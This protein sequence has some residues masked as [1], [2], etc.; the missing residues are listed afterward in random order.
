[1]ALSQV[2]LLKGI[3]AVVFDLVGT[4]VTPE[5][6]VEAVYSAVGKQFG[7]K[8]DATTI[9]VRFRKAFRETE[10]NGLPNV[11]SAVDEGP[12]PSPW[13]TSEQAEYDRWKSI[14]TTS[15]PDV[16]DLDACF[17]ALWIHFGD[18]RHWRSYDDAVLT[19]DRLRQQ[20]MAVALASNFDARAHRVCDGL[21]SIKL[22]TQRFISSEVGFRK[23]A[24]KF[25]DAVLEGLRKNVTDLTAKEVLMVGD[26]R[27][28]DVGGARAAGFRAVRVNRKTEPNW[29]EIGSL[30]ALTG[31]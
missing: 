31:L 3:R 18:Y 12:A 26:D 14:V 5:P 19:L 20:G 22:I 11:D 15:L 7:S 16:A 9:G 17:S 13:I 23:P 1:M 25:F 21:D 6:A 8:L 10:R 2:P 27:E 30:H 24:R 29:D 28:N 4:L